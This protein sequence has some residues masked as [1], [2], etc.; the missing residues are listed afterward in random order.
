MLIPCKATKP[1]DGISRKERGMQERTG[2]TFIRSMSQVDAGTP[3]FIHDA[4]Q[5]HGIS[6]Q[7][8]NNLIAE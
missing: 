7:W 1:P 6:S 8:S 3:K 2:R 5:A 4:A